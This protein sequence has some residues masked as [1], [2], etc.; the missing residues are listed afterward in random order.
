[1]GQP[2]IKCLY[3][4]QNIYPYIKFDKFFTCYTC[5]ESKQKK[6]SFLVS[7]SHANQPFELF[8]IDIW[9]PYS[10]ISLHGHKFFVTI[11]DDYTRFC[12]IFPMGS[13][14]ETRDII[15]HL[16]SY[17]ERQ[18]N[19]TLKII[20]TNNG[21]KI[22]METYFLSKHIVHQ[23]TYVETPEQNM[24][25][26]RK[27]QH[28]LNVTRALLFHSDLPLSFWN[29]AL[30][31]VFY[32]INCT[33]TPLLDN[34]SPYEKLH[35][36]I[37]DISM[38]GIFG[39]LCYATTL[40]SHR[41]K[42]GSRATPRVIIGF[43]P[44]TKGYMYLNLNTHKIEMSYHVTFHENCFPSSKKLGTIKFDIWRPLPNI[45]ESNDTVYFDTSHVHN[46]NTHYDQT[47]DVTNNVENNSDN[48]NTNIDVCKST[49][50]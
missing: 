42:L 8:H 46:N 7:K 4:L 44:N 12:W 32:L 24:F 28:L 13:K 40:S 29:Y 41:K 11:V 25:V 15:K 31:H 2:S 33:P 26:E 5:H 49:H 39:C 19:R 48:E 14:A 22:N 21:V 20:Q 34:C 30:L 38:L 36:K 47:F 1:M 50:V 23:K 18:F 37:C 9:G 16:I 27:H 3:D 35:G 45:Y 6:Y 10:T 17:I 43:Q